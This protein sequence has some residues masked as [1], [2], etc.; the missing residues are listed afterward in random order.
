MHGDE[1]I[2]FFLLKKVELTNFHLV[3]LTGPKNKVF[4][5][6]VKSALI[7]ITAQPGALVSVKGILKVC[8]YQSL[9][10]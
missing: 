3:E 7:P 5:T 9:E 10:M 6:L 8:S 1:I 4:L 2:I